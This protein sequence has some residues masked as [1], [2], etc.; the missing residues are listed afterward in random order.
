M[1]K[2]RQAAAHERLEYQTLD[3]NWTVRPQAYCTYHHRY[4]TEKQIRLHRCHAKHGGVCGRYQDMK[5]VYVRRMRQEQ[6][7]DKQLDQ[8]KKIETALLKLVKTFENIS[9]F[10]DMMGEMYR[11]ESISKAEQS[12]SNG[13]INIVECNG[14]MMDDGK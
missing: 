3:G 13:N 10:C 1:T 8:L 2:P 5:G 12:N 9:T 7:Y 11:E 14:N 6:F 4:L